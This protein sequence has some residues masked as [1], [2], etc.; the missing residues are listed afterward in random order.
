MRLVLGMGER[1]RPA[2]RRDLVKWVEL[3]AFDQNAAWPHDAEADPAAKAGNQAWDAEQINW[4]ERL[5]YALQRPHKPAVPAFRPDRISDNLNNLQALFTKA[6]RLGRGGFG[7]FGWN[8][9]Q[10]SEGNKKTRRQGPASGAHL[11]R[12][13]PLATHTEHPCN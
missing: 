7:W 11:K 13:E 1:E 3:P 9:A 8:A 2:F 4:G 5:S 12:F 10:W 6:S